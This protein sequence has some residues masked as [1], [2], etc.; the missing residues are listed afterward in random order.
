MLSEKDRLLAGKVRR[1]E[2][3]IEVKEKVAKVSRKL[4]VLK[5][6]PEVYDENF[7]TLA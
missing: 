3:P 6:I 2:D 7:P 1:V 5:A 4:S